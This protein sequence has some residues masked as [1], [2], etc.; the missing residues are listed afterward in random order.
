MR[1]T[2]LTGTATASR[3]TDAERRAL[4]RRTEALRRR[5]LGESP[6]AIA[7]AMRGRNGVAPN[8][9]ARLVAADVLAALREAQALL[10]GDDLR[11]SKDLL[12]VLELERL[13]SM[14]RHATRILDESVV[15][16]DRL[17]QLRAID[18]TLRISARRDALMG[19][20]A[21]AEVPPSPEADEVD[22]LKQ[23]REERMLKA[24][25]SA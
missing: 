15:T 6:Q 19:L 7:V 14:Q 25:G 2:C 17:D 10:S 4:L 3:T 20:A 9:S 21:E 11:E 1:T 13:D 12:R 18:R 16:G 23:R 5:I 24:A 22:E 8:Y